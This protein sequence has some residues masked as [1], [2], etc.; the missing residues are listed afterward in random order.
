[1]QSKSNNIVEYYNNC[2][3]DYRIFWDLNRSRAMHAGFWDD[4]TQTLPEALARE[5][6]ILAE[7]AAITKE[8]RVLDAGCGIGGSSFYLARQYGCRVVGITLSQKQVQTA[9]VIAKKENLEDLV[10]FEEMDFCQTSFPNASF[11]VVWGIESICH[12]DEKLLFV[13]EAYRILKEGG[14]LI[15]ADGFSVKEKNTRRE[16]EEMS[17]WL[18]GWGV[19]KLETQKEFMSHL[20]SVGFS[21]IN[22]RNVNSFVMPSSKRLYWISFPAIV[23]SKLGEWLRIRKKIQTN[24]IWAAYYQYITLKQG[25]WEYGIFSAKKSRQ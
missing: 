22:Y 23:L 12:A 16:N 19:D 8:D 21:E 10:H 24:N 20:K 15:I 7:I 3:S 25:L 2:E 13:K 11:D 18:K 1:M 9:T 14:R 17:R 4:Q 6:A 5:N